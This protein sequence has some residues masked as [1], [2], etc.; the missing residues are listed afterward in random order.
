MLIPQKPTKFDI[1][2]LEDQ[3]LDPFVYIFRD[4]PHLPLSFLSTNIINSPSFNQIFITHFRTLIRSPE[5]CIPAYGRATSM[6]HCKAINF[7]LKQIRTHLKKEKKSLAMDGRKSAFAL[8]SSSSSTPSLLFLF[9]PFACERD[10]RIFQLLLLY[11]IFSFF[12]YIYT[13]SHSL[14]CMCAS[15]LAVKI[16]DFPSSSL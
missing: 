11:F 8:T 12:I 4:H 16:Q 15:Q 13:Y 7:I 3:S 14:S 1:K 6:I 5:K 10:C 2:P 9:F